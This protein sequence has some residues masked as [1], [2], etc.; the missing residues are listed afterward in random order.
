MVIPNGWFILQ[1]PKYKTP[2]VFDLHERGL[3]PS[4]PSVTRECGACLIIDENM[5]TSVYFKYVAQ[6]HTVL[7]NMSFSWLVREGILPLTT[8]MKLNGK[9]LADIGD[10]GAIEEITRV[11][12]EWYRSYIPL[13]GDG[14]VDNAELKKKLVFSLN[15]GK[16]QFREN[17]KRKNSQW[18][19]P[20]LA[21]KIQDFKRVLYGLVSGELYSDYCTRGGEDSEDGLIRKIQLF[22][23]IYDSYDPES[24]LKPD[25]NN[26]ASEDEIWD[27][28]IAYAGTELE[29]KRVCQSMEAVFRPLSEMLS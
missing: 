5:Q 17:L 11:H 8:D 22:S 10:P 28:W 20:A 26:W 24:L 2:S 6:G 12:G 19:E 29:A 15:E 9:E 4:M 16:K 21:R 27:C 3:F 1:P 18:I 13:Q 7:N 14:A 23:R 25:G